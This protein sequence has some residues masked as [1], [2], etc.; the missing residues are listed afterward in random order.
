MKKLLKDP[1]KRRQLL[2]AGGAVAVLMLLLV[3]RKKSA[4][5]ET[6]GTTEAL[7]LPAEPAPAPVEGGGGIG[8][9]SG[10]GTSG[11][12]GSTGGELGQIGTQ[13]SQQ[14]AAQNTEQQNAFGALINALSGY[15][16]GLPGAGEPAA[17]PA[18]AKTP[19]AQHNLLKNEQA[20]NPRAGDPY[21]AT[22]YQ[23]KPAHDY[24]KPIPGGVGPNHSLIILPG[25][26]SG[27]TPAH[28]NADK[29]N[30]RKGEPFKVG[31][32]K[33]KPA[34]IYPHAVKGGVGPRHNT[35]IV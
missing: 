16:N 17:A 21:K 28:T 5:T 15:T 3:L 12:G 34:H 9:G 4:G 13:I 33:N 1:K 23:G 2:I 10:G 25:T 26:H 6:A 20:G 18:Q 30:V 35:I 24:G 32:Y 31:K 7:S 29:G 11:S 22:T 8:G 27:T 14:L 19:L